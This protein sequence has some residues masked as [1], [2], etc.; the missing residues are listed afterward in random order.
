MER[1]NVRP[2]ITGFAQLRLPQDTDVHSVRRKL[3][4]DLYYVRNVS[5][6]LD[7]RILLLTLQLFVTAIAEAV[8]SAM[9]LPSR[10][11]IESQ[12][13]PLAEPADAG[14]YV[15]EPVPGFSSECR[16]SRSLHETQLA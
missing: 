5:A 14:S 9:A 8:L 10:E 16:G 12:L 15:D 4:Y 7:L 11:A 3:A 6:W 1:T 2:G 13:I